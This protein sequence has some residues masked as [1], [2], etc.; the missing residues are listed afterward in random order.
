MIR[1]SARRSVGADP[2]GFAVVSLQA[3]LT[4]GLLLGTGAVHAPFMVETLVWFG[5]A[6]LAVISLGNDPGTLV[7]P[8]PVMLF[9]LW[10]A[11]SLTW[12]INE[13]ATLTGIKESMPILIGTLCA[14]VVL[15]NDRLQTALIH[16]ASITFWFTALVLTIDPSS[17]F[18]AATPSVPAL[19]GWRGH[20]AHKNGLAVYLVM[21]GAILLTL[22]PRSRRRDATL[23]L[24]VVLLFGA[25]SATGLI[26][27]TMVAAAAGWIGVMRRP[28]RRLRASA[29]AGGVLAA[30]AGFGA[31]AF[32]LPTVLEV[33]GKDPSLTGRTDIWRGVISAIAERP[34]LGHGLGA[35]FTTPQ[36]QAAIAISNE[37]G[38]PVP[39]SHQGVLNVWLHLG[40]IGLLLLL[41]VYGVTV[42]VALRIRARDE[43]SAV[44]ALVITWAIAL[45]S[46]AEAVLMGSILAISIVLQVMVLRGLTRP[47]TA[48]PAGPGRPLVESGE[49]A[50]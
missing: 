6:G 9:L 12:T 4:L 45:L 43:R 44:A 34:V 47:P 25:R 31:Y 28:E 10:V 1:S 7:I 17:R 8:L 50:T 18:L 38:Y 5:V 41:T 20:F 29:T 33:Y 16:T 23:A 37:A 21:G 40:A 39:H 13:A 19:P 3:A 14:A 35:V 24:G 32:A 36:S 26:V 22:A 27:A 11:G 30:V 46:L 2:S 42:F 15:P 48:S 49:V